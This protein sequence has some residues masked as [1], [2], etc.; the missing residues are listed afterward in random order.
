MSLRRT[1][2][3]VG[4][5]VLAAAG[6]AG[7]ATASGNSTTGVTSQMTATVLD[8]LPQVRSVAHAERLAAS[9]GVSGTTMTIIQHADGVKSAT[10][11]STA[12]GTVHDESH[13]DEIGH[14]FFQCYRAQS[15]VKPA[16]NT[17]C[18]N[19]T[20]LTG[21]GKLLLTQPLSPRWLDTAGPNTVVVGGTGEFS[22]A[23][24]QATVTRLDNG[25]LFDLIIV[26]EL[27]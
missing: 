11:L 8:G 24:G 27:L 26:V 7:A 2:A 20:E 14:F 3:L 15:T 17:W 6:L 4:A 9:A 18:E 12:D 21:R 23:Q 16:P 13:G 10:E 1:T 5:A 22:G 19:A 25:H